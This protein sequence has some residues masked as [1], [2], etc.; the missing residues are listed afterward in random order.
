MATGRAT[1]T[2]SIAAGLGPLEKA[3]VVMS[4]MGPSAASQLVDHLR[5]ED[6]ERLL[7][8]AD[9]LP[10]IGPELLEAI[11]AE[12]EGAF[13]AGTGA[14]DNL[15]NLEAV[16]EGRMI[17]AE[18]PPPPEERD[19]WAE[20]AA[21]ETEASAAILAVENVQ[22][23]VLAVAK[24][25]STE[26]ATML[27]EV[28]REMAGRV[29]RLMPEAREAAPAVVATV[30]AYLAE[31]IDALSGSS[32]DPSAMAAVLNEMERDVVDVLIGE[33]GLSDETEK[34]LRGALFAFEDLAGLSNE[35]RTTIL[36]DVPGDELALSLNGA[37]AELVE[38][39]LTSVS[40]R[41]RRM[42]EAQLNGAAAPDAVRK[43]RRSIARRA[44]DLSREGRITIVAED[45]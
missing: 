1:R 28:P 35:D 43:A 5:N 30:E 34:R 9:R 16:F 39:A 6:R 42:V 15:A 20:F 18:P 38:A 17:E 10:D 7:A 29:L 33:A 4:A 31:R 44:L 45:A 24:M 32:D 22:M 23:T 41:T 14:T 21:L 37:E 11:V 27:N 36:D 13:A 8:A 19:V 26:A 3:V 2:P 25:P 12:F 40:P